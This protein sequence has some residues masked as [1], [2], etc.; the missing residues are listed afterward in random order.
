MIQ[1]RFEEDPSR[2]SELYH[3]L[4][5]FRPD[6]NIAELCEIADEYLTSRHLDLHRPPRDFDTQGPLRFTGSDHVYYS[7]I[8]QNNRQHV[9]NS[10]FLSDLPE[11]FSDLPIVEDL[12]QMF[13]ECGDLCADRDY[14]YRNLF[15]Y[16]IWN[17]LPQHI[18][19]HSRSA[20]F[21]LPLRGVQAP[22]EWATP[23]YVIFRSHT[24]VCA[25]MIN[26]SIIHG[27]TQSTGSRMFL[28]L[29]GFT[30]PFKQ[31]TENISIPEKF[32]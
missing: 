17:E 16:D 6:P 9:W 19:D 28:S 24:Y 21:N 12:W 30:Q 3:E 11:D 4:P 31:I 8:D 26:T 29:T 1:R 23:D 22:V 25:T 32:L 27:S 2:D 13:R 7:R 20:G 14:L 15:I 18:D 5:W 10:V